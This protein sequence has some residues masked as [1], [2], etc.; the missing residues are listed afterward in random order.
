MRV[1]FVN[2][3]SAGRLI[4]QTKC[5]NGSPI[6]PR[7]GEHILFPSTTSLDDMLVVVK[8]VI[9]RFPINEPDRVRVDVEFVKQIPKE[10]AQ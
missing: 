10:D 3:M 1:T 4:A 5:T 8:G 7:V 2:Y 6:I 9:Y